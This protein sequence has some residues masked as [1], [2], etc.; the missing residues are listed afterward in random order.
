MSNEIITHL[1]CSHVA[2][3]IGTPTVVFGGGDCF[4]H[5]RARFGIEQLQIDDALQIGLIAARRILVGID[6]RATTAA[7]AAAAANNVAAASDAAKCATKLTRQRRRDRRR[8]SSRQAS[9]HRRRHWCPRQ[10][11]TGELPLCVL[12]RQS[13]REAR[14]NAGC[15]CQ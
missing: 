14:G 2:E 12:L 10:A 6:K 11:I 4:E 5:S 3:K 9:R 15:C 8:Q 13:Q 1:D 7:A